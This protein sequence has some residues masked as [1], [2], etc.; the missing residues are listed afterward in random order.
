M[1][2]SVGV[3]LYGHPVTAMTP[4]NALD[5]Q[6]MLATAVHAQPGVY[7]L[8]LGSGVST[9]AGIPTGWGVVREL[10]RRAAAASA[11]NDPD[12]PGQAYDDPEA[13][14]TE[15][16]DG[17][18][19]GYSNLLA[20][21]APTP[22][23]RRALLAGFFEPT[24]DD[25]EAGL[26]VPSEAHRAV[27]ELVKRGAVRVVLTTNF[28]RLTERALEDVGVS[29]QVISHTGALAGMAPLQHA[30]ATVIKLHGD[31]ADL[32]QRNTVDELAAYP[33]E[34]DA[35]LDRVLSEYGLLISGWSADW[36]QAL[37][38][39]IERLP[40]RRYPL[41]WDARSAK[42]ENAKRLLALQS[43]TV[44]TTEDANDLFAG[45]S[46]RLDALDRLSEPPLTTALA[47]ERL[48]RYLPDD[49]RRIDLND[50]I[51]RQVSQVVS[52][53][54]D[55]PQQLGGD[56]G[57]QF[58]DLL[59]GS[60]AITTPLSR[61][62][63]V[64]VQH[65][66]DGRFSDLWVNA[67]QRLLKAHRPVDGGFQDD[68]I[69]LRRYP[70]LFYLRCVGVACAALERDDL[71]IRLLTKPTF[72]PQF[73]NDAEFTA[74]HALG[75]Y[76]VLME[77][78]VKSLPRYPGPG[79]LYPP[80]HLLRDVTRPVLE[81]L[82]PDSGDYSRRHDDYEYYAALVQHCTAS[83]YQGPASG[84]F[85]GDHGWSQHGLLA[86]IR[87]RQRAEQADLDWPWFKVIG[88]RDKRDAV[89]TD[90]QETLKKMTRWG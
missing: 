5:P 26:K 85:I 2:P 23:A 61:L 87:F 20:S 77:G 33:P 3:L 66:V 25:A 8:M 63:V 68:V 21:L 76:E 64:G 15:H 17:Q 22:A 28:D 7:A 12:A 42:G 37:V 31:Y 27:A 81:D 67:L 62:A 75:G 48:K 4:T 44:L 16:G 78:V 38:A 82:V 30:A 88:G 86:E 60:D 57:Q 45:L 58:D 65:D 71:L 52:A 49:R 84:E 55:F 10:V 11:P 41:F 19:L 72:R 83:K 70:A 69:A 51:D 29:P 18:P 50:L 36:D 90:L 14:W 79:W 56:R 39:A 53:V 1:G 89:L 24:Q 73:Y 54:A 47:I 35:L 74:A 6:V 34:W 80:S 46:T 13:W 43:G 59:S 9:G 32:L 40:V